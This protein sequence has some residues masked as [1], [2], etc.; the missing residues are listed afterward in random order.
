MQVLL[1]KSFLIWKSFFFF[2]DQRGNVAKSSTFARKT[3]FLILME[4]KQIL[5][6]ISSKIIIAC[7]YVARSVSDLGTYS[8]LSLL[9]FSKCT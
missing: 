7:T 6:S 3:I 5:G 9:L 4:E 1:E 8:I 2:S